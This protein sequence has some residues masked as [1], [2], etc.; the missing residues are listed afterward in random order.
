MMVSVTFVES[1]FAVES[2]EQRAFCL[3]KFNGERKKKRKTSERK[4]FYSCYNISDIWNSSLG[5][6]QSSK[7]N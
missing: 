5:T 6:L 4:T 2:S 1:R 3:I 7:F